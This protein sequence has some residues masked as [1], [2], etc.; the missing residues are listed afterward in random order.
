MEDCDRLKA[1]AAKWERLTSLGWEFKSQSN[2]G[3]RLNECIERMSH[4]QMDILIILDCMEINTISEMADFL[5]I[6]KSTL[7]IVMNKLDT[8]G[9]V[10]KEYPQIGDG[11]RVYFKISPEGR[12]IFEKLGEQYIETLSSFYVKFNEEGKRLFREGVAGLRK[13]TNAEKTLIAIM[14]SRE[15]NSSKYS[16]EVIQIAKDIAFFFINCRMNNAD[17]A[18]RLSGKFTQNQLH[19]LM[20]ILGGLDTLTKLE[21]HLGSSGST[22]S[23]GV[24]K[25]VEKGYLYKE[26]PTAGQDGRKVFIRLTEKGKEVLSATRAAMNEQF[27][28]YLKSFDDENVE[29][30]SD[31]CDCLIRAFEKHR[32]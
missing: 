12:E 26:Y 27:L 15:V 18:E 16:E 6:S 8:K 22:L 21:N 7:S 3:A 23:I 10:L 1:I 13:S 28:G 19:L 9:L 31:S 29:L 17:K 2:L 25:L 14:A 4:R 11:R 20:C 24:S 32:I 30:F 5:K